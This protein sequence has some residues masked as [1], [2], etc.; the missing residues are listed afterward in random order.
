VLGGEG[1]K[2]KKIASRLGHIKRAFYAHLRTLKNLLPNAMPPPPQARSG[3]PSKTS[4][5]H[6]RRLKDYVQKNPF[7]SARQLKN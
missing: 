5:I 4:T 2:A 3:R 6:D 7:K 1:I